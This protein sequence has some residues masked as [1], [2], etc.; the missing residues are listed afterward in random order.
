MVTD[1]RKVRQILLNLLSNAVKF[2]DAGSVA[3]RVRAGASPAEPIEFEVAD[4]GIGIPAEHLE[5][6]FDPFWQVE[7]KSTTRRVG[8][9][10][11]GLSVV[12][13]LAELLGGDVSVRSE[14]ERGSTFTVRVP[15][16]AVAAAAAAT[17]GSRLSALGSRPERSAESREPTAESRS[18]SASRRSAPA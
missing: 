6:I 5:H 18:T 3:L 9:T 13:R 10:G 11:L 1:P 15:R 2:T 4:T 14:A 7:Q 17:A 8:G 12:R 16:I